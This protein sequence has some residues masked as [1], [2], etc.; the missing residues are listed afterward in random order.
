MGSNNDFRETIEDGSTVLGAQASTFSPT[1]I[2]IYGELGLDFVWLDFEHAGPSP[3]DS[4]VFENLTR[5]AEVSGTT[6]LVRI[7][8]G[9]PALIRK[10]LDAG[11]Q[12]LLIPRVDSRDEVRTALEAT[13]FEYDGE[14]GERGLAS[15]RASRWGNADDHVSVEDNEV[16]M[17]VMIE[18]LGAVEE[19]ER[20]LEVP[21]LGFVF[22]GP[23]DLSVQVG[24]PMDRSH[25]EVRDQIE[26]IEDVCR[27]SG[28]PMGGI[29]ND[30][31]KVAANIQSGYQIIR[32][33]GDLES[34]R[35][36]L[37][38]RLDQIAE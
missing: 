28:V 37:Q 14:P 27:S 25:P 34:I 20:I 5:A 33:G 31:T 4:T 38:H 9:D 29:Q 6:L 2:E 24:H 22:V 3:Y 19:L 35:E 36:T 15:S 16:C 21:E 10:V 23:G 18:K 30:P 32:I 7:P 13:R 17:G 11:V 12:N 8:S 26:E 1:V